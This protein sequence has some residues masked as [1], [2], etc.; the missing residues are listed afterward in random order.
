[1]KKV[2]R[3]SRREFLK[4]TA[5]ATAGLSVMSIG[6]KDVSAKGLA[7][8]S[9]TQINPDIPNT[10][11][12]SCTDTKMITNTTSARAASTFGGTSGQNIFVNTAQVE[13]NMDAMAKQLTG[14]ST[15]ALAWSTIFRKPSTKQWSAVKTAIKVNC[16]NTGIMPK[17]AVVGKIC[18][19]FINLGV[20]PGNITIFDACSNASGST[21]YTPYI[22][23]ATVKKGLPFGVVVSSITKDGPNVPVGTSTL[24][25]TSILAVQNGTSIT[26]PIDILVNCAVNKGHSSSH[27]GFT[28]CMKNHTGTLKYSCPSTEEIITENQSE[29]IIGGSNGAPCRQ[30][31][32]IIDSLWAATTGPSDPASHLPCTLTMGTVAPVVD[33]QVALKIRQDTMNS[34]PNQGVIDT[35]LQRFNINKANLEWLVVPSASTS[36]ANSGRTGFTNANT[37]KLS[38]R[39]Q[40]GLLKQTNAMLDIPLM[41]NVPEIAVMDLKGHQIKMLEF[42]G[43]PILYWDGTDKN[44]AMVAT[45]SYIVQLK[46]GAIVTSS[47]LMVSR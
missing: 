1:M 27:G 47:A 24:K 36:I 13:A 34:T 16:I 18:Q 45:G 12:V 25:C 28:M 22:S 8:T 39:V 23:T 31:L 17:I 20:S 14:K 7:W 3:K 35:W 4:I 6:K 2:N 40:N 5:I 33:Y 42:S 29:A 30:Q 11:V 21:K 37:G 26:Y 41:D 38:V 44:G 46:A 19:E 10:R 43:Q 32:C 9:A 15:A